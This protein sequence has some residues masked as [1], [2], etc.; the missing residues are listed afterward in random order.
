MHGQSDQLRLARPA[1]QR[2]ALDR[3]AGI[4]LAEYAATYRTW[5]AAG[6]ELDERRARIGELRREADLLAHG[7]AEIEAAA[8]L[9]GEDVDLAAAAGRL[10]HADALR[11]AAHQAHDALLGAA[12]DPMGDSADV[13]ALLGTARRALDQQTGADPELDQLA[14]RL[15]ELAALTAELG[16]DFGAYEAGLDADPQR[17]EQLEARRSVLTALVRKYADGPP[18][19]LTAVATWAARATERLAEIDVSDEALAALAARRDELGARV[20]R[21]ATDLTARRTAAAGS[22]GA[23]VTNE[24]GGLAM[25][26]AT[27]TVTVS[28]RGAAGPDGADEIEILLQPQADAPALP[29]ARG[30][31]GGELSRVMLAIELCLAGTAPVPTMVFD[32]VDAGV[33]GR[34]ALE[35]GRRLARLAHS[36][37]RPQVIAVTHLAQVAAFADTH[38]VVDKR[39]A[40]SSP[41]AAV[42]AS[43]VRV[44]AGD[45]RRAELA[46]MLAGTDSR[47]AL[48]H[49][50]ELL[51]GAASDAGTSDADISRSRD[52][53]DAPPAHGRESR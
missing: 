40:Q 4:D 24:L 46:R 6:A 29:L 25:P 28:P 44:V 14:G 13:A 15:D 31:S 34:A 18:A 3:Y 39:T 20:D 11:L 50:A 12:D 53:A 32:E 17:L 27:C 36:T 23:A 35:V 33:G 41:G 52:L 10:A 22:L 16:A 45:E 21:L 42:V 1:E 26:H 19:D 5:R 9:P 7:L 47:T 2:A 49:A 8:P 30:A 48:D 38:I 37:G 43:D 51:A